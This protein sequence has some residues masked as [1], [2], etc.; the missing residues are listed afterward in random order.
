MA[1]C[2]NLQKHLRT[3]VHS[4]VEMQAMFSGAPTVN[5]SYL[6]HEMDN[7]VAVHILNKTRFWATYQA[8]HVRSLRNK[9]LQFYRV[10]CEG[11]GRP[12]ERGRDQ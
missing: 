9:K 11:R 8:P 2:I 4:T 7:W 1:R 6:G 12:P 3:L 10:M 5:T